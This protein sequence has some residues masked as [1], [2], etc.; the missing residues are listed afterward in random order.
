M[1]GP[2]GEKSDKDGYAGEKERKT[3][4]E[5]D[6]QCKCGLEGEWTI[7]V[8]DTKLGCVKA[9]CQIYR[10]HIEV[11][12]DAVE[13]EEQRYVLSIGFWG[14]FTPKQ[15]TKELCQTSPIPVLYFKSGLAG[16]FLKSRK[17]EL[18]V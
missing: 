14:H 13:V 6:G 9:T 1:N 17:A 16:N 5:V 15:P 4:G 10:P 3:E 18:F 12:N 11:G 7:G 2:L 8:G